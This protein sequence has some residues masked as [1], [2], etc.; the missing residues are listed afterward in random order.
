MNTPFA[1][2]DGNLACLDR[3]RDLLAALA[4]LF[5]FAAMAAL[6]AGT[7][8][9]EGLPGPEQERMRIGDVGRGEL[10]FRGD[11]EG[12]LYPAPQLRTDVSMAVSGLV[13]RVNVR[14]RFHNPEDRWV[15]GIYVFPLPEGAAVDRLRM[16][17]GDRFIAGVVR[18]RQEARAEYEKARASGR[19][20]SLVEQERPNIFTTSVAN[21]G[22]DEEIV[23]EIEYQETLDYRDGTFGL[24]FP[25]VVGPRY[26]PGQPRTAGLGAAG[27]GQVGAAV[28]DADRISPPVLHPDAGKINPV[29]LE[30]VIDAGFPL[31]TVTSPSHAIVTQALDDDR[32]AITLTEADVPADRDFVLHWRPEIGD[33]PDAGLF[34][35]SGG[36]GHHYA[37]IMLMPPDAGGA[38]AARPTREIVFV[39]DTSGSM[40]GTSIVQAKAALRLALDRLTRDDRFNIVRFD[41]TTEALFAEPTPADARHL[42][43][44][45]RFVDR[46][47]AH[48]G[49][50]MRPALE[51]ALDAT[52]SDGRV[53]QVVFLTD[54][55]IGNEAQL[56][57]LIRQRLGDRRLFTVGIGPAP[58][59]YF[60]R[61]AAEFGRGTFVHIDDVAEVGE[62]MASLFVK[63][64]RPVVTDLALAWPDGVTVEG[65]P[66]T[67]PDLYAG[68]PVVLAARLSELRDHLALRGRIGGDSW[69]L[70]LPLA[71]GREGSGIAQLWARERIEALEDSR[72]EGADPETVRGAIVETAL[73]HNLVSVHISLVAVDV[74][75]RRPED[76]VAARRE[77]PTNLPHG[78]DFEAVFGE[79]AERDAGTVPALRKAS[80]DAAPAMEARLIGV[81]VP[82][83]ASTADLR[84]AIGLILL[85]ISAALI[86][87]A[88]R[89]AR[90]A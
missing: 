2:R 31:G 12:S 9:G 86:A 53:R 7:A 36:D 83:G 20:A 18:E 49:T 68:E 39:I 74:T 61:K 17:V 5:G 81:A 29:S 46:L 78:W 67:L 28:P 42:A 19:T 16:Q 14:Q 87:I 84:I 82:Q 26:I 48:G 56:F 55:A 15:E 71:A 88:A 72:Y 32:T 76:V 33:A 11:E 89:S 51:R 73:A 63:L 59:S 8:R 10:L 13:N 80:L 69:I 54:G 23:I 52:R 22:P 66:A 60:M 4:L 50:Q 37:L 77:V 43:E 44:A 3:T 30:I 79:P 47:D 75:P 65:H 58:N 35:Q 64:E 1:T 45:R 41:S 62:E 24:R 85:M 25:M 6:S 34:V 21:V 38:E 90:I 40:A 70:T 27:W 57:S